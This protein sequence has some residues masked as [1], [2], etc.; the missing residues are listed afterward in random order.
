MSIFELKDVISS[1]SRS[2]LEDIENEVNKDKL[3]STPKIL[4]KTNDHIEGKLKEASSPKHSP[5]Q[6]DVSDRKAL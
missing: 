6:I 3:L 5:K 2:I 1:N 4:K